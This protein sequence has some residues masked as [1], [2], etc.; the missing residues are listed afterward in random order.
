M[1]FPYGDTRERL[2]EAM[3]WAYC[4]DKEHQL[5]QCL[6]RL[7]HGSDNGGQEYICILG[8]DFAPLSF[9]F[10]YHKLDNIERFEKGDVILKLGSEPWLCGGLIYSGPLPK[11]GENTDQSTF[12]T[13]IDKHNGWSIHT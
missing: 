4:I 2:R 10:A 5:L 12:T 1:L 8:K 13:N 11:G 6:Y 3:K 7:G 9:T